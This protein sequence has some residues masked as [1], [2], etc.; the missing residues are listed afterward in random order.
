MKSGPAHEPFWRT[1][2]LEDLNAE[3]WESLCDGCGRCCLVKFEYDDA[4]EIGYT[5]VACRLLDLNLCRCVDYPNRAHEVDDCLQLTPEKV[6]QSD[7]LPPTCAYRLVAEGKPLYWW[8][9]LV[10]GSADTVHEAGISVRGRVVSE[11]NVSPRAQEDR[12]VEWPR[13]NP[14]SA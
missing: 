7:W 10:S 6:R 5:D 12:I 9:P 8:H 13:K 4:Q 11:R 3:E 14:G 1:K 2:R